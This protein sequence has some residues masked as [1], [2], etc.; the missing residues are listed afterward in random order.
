MSALLKR[1]AL[2]LCRISCI[3][4]LTAFAAACSTTKE[5]PPLEKVAAVDLNRFMGDWYVLANIPTFLEKGAHNAVE[6]Y[7]MNADGSIAIKFTFYKDGFDGE[8]RTLRM[9]GTIVEG[10]SN[11]EWK[12]SP[13][14]PLR[15]PYYTID[16]DPD[17]KWVI[18]ATP[19]RG[20][21][22]IMAR[23]PSLPENQ[24]NSLIE[25]MV[26]RGFNREA[27]QIVPQKWPKQG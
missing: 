23:E 24:L 8:L 7:Q 5:L 11:A 3:S 6:N 18:V 1:I 12:V 27:I 15:F 20:Y 17:Y 26:A 16:L 25:K 9:T 13:F 14:W 22:W 4:S 19:N 2:K 10:T 21:L